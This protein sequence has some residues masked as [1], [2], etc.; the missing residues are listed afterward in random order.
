MLNHLFG[1][2]GKQKVT[3]LATDGNQHYDYVVTLGPLALT[4]NVMYV[5]YS[6]SLSGRGLTMVRRSSQKQ[7]LIDIL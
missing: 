3:C 5:A 1:F 2:L 6:A 4:I 7:F